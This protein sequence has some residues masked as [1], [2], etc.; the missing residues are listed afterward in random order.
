L[1]KC[2]GWP[3]KPVYVLH[4]AIGRVILRI[5]VKIIWSNPPKKFEFL[6]L[7]KCILNIEEF[8][9]FF[10]KKWQILPTIYHREAKKKTSYIR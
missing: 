5:G 3:K 7:L 1:V 6:V 10:R 2:T 9:F 4:Q 8:V